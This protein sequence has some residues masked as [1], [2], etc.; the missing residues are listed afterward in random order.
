MKRTIHSNNAIKQKYT[1]NIHLCTYIYT[2]IPAKQE[3]KEGKPP[4]S[5]HYL[6]APAQPRHLEPQPR[7]YLSL[8]FAATAPLLSLPLPPN[9]AVEYPR[10]RK[11]KC[12]Q[13]EW[14]VAG[15]L[16]CMVCCRERK[17]EC[18]QAENSGNKSESDRGE[19]LHADMK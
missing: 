13:A 9:R 16:Q 7:T 17:R 15:V 11:R 3:M 14:C 2:K 5:S 8:N 4:P 19:R 10:E 1:R 12:T 6:P 18:T